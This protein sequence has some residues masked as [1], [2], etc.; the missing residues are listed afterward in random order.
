MRKTVTTHIRRRALLLGGLLAPLAACATD[1]SARPPAV[2]TPPAPVPFGDLETRYDGR[3]GIFAASIGSGA[4]VEHRADER[5]AFCST[6]KTLAAAAV[7]A[8]YPLSHL[9]SRVTFTRD[10]IRS[11]SPITQDHVDSGMTIG[12]LCD[13]AIRFSDGTAGNLLLDDIGGPRALTE[14]LRNLGDPVSR[15]DNYEPELNRDTPDSVFDTT[16]ARAIAA[17]YRA[18]LGVGPGVTGARL[19]A[20]PSA[21]K[22]QLLL[23]WLRDNKTGAHRI[24]AAAPPGWTVADKTG[25][26]DYGRANDVAIAFPPTGA[27]LVIA[28][29]A[30]RN[31]GYDAP[32]S[33]EFVAAAAGRIFDALR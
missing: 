3:V 13:A 5:F 24:R 25:T 32:P 27:P 2:R 12:E 20:I 9:S 4:T 8:R 11:I 10:A 16:T 22:Q 19:E 1:I 28:I 6:F 7:L 15:M 21:D 30:D 31:G 26:G 17:D 23:N 14:Y 33:E 29:L 18:I